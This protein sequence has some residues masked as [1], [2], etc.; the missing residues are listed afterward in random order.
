MM[1][2]SLALIAGVFD[3]QPEDLT[4]DDVLD[5]ITLYWGWA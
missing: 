1:P 4:R 5:N 2:S 3:G